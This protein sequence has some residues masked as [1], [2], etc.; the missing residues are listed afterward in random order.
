MIIPNIE[1]NKKTKTKLG[2]Q[3]ILIL[4]KKFLF[5]YIGIKSIV[6]LKTKVAITST[7]N[8]S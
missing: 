1:K 7:T 3:I 2:N 6:V 4:L 8:F 5:K